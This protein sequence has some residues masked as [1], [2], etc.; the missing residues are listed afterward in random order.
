MVLA[1]EGYDVRCARTASAALD[2]A[3][4]RQPALILFERAEAQSAFQNQLTAQQQQRVQFQQQTQ[5]EINQ[6]RNELQRDF[7]FR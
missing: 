1:S 4:Q 6:L 7:L 2:L 5:F 3:Q